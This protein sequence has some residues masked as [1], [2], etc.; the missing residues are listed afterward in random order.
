MADR[1]KGITI[2]I[3]GDTS[4]LSKALSGVNKDIKNTQ[5]QLKD[6]NK[7]LKLDPTNS[8]LIS[9]KM[10]LLG[11]SIGQTKDKLNQ[12]KS[13][14]S[15][16]DE[17]L[18]NGTVTQ[19]QYDAWQREIIATENE[20]KNLQDQLKNTDNVVQATLK[21]AGDKVSAA[22]KKISDIGSGLTTHVTAPIVAAGAASVAAWHEMDDAMDTI[23]TK[24]GAT[25]DALQ[26]MQDRAQNIA[27]TIPTD[28][29][30]AADAVGEVHTRFGL[31]GDALEDLSTQFVEFATLNNT[32]VST[33]VDNVSKVLAAFNMDTSDAGGMLNVLNSVGQ[34]TGLSMDEL[35]KLLSSNAASLQEMGLNA[36]QGAQFLGQASMAGMDTSAAMMGL[37]T[38]LKNAASDGVSMEKAMS[39]WQKTMQSSASDTDKLNATIDLFGSKAG[40]Q[41]YN[42][43]KAGKLNL[44]DLKSSMSDFE[45]N[46]SDTFNN[47]LDP[48]DNFTTMMNQMKVV[49]A[50]IGTSIGEVLGP[51]LQQV[52]E[53]IKMLT[54]AWEGLSPQMQ[55]TIV[56]AAMIAAAIGPVLIVVGKVV[57]GVGSVIKVL[58]MLANPVGIVIA[59][60]AALVAAMVVLYQKNETF[61]NGVNAMFDKIKEGFEQVKPYFQQLIDA[62][63]QL[64]TTIQPV[65][66]Q[67]GEFLMTY[68]TGIVSGISAALQP[69]IAV[70]TNVVQ[71]ITNIVKAF[72]ALFHGDLDT[73]LMYIGQAIQ[74]GLNIVKNVIMTVVNFIRGFLSAF[75]ISI[76]GI[77]TTVMTVIQTIIQTVLTAIQ[78]VVTTIVNTISTVVS[79][80]VNG[81]KTTVVSVWEA[82]KD[83]TTSIWNGIKNAIVTPINAAKEAVRSA[84]DAI[85]GIF[86]STVLKLDI[87]IPHISVSGGVA[88]FGIGGQ[89][90]LPSFNV[91][92]YKQGG[93][94]TNPTIFGMQNGRLLG[95]GEAGAEAVLPLEQLQPM[96]TNGVK[97]A[98]AGADFGGYQQNL[99]ITSPTALTPSEVAR[100]T[101]LATRNMVA[102]MKGGV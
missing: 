5:S 100:Q 42:A 52:A 32:D 7:L 69:M 91:D 36:A 88:P 89:G 51:I 33:S 98:L 93:I 57:T 23:V 30:T 21:A 25:G 67:I 10:K 74:N 3:G 38:A 87:K 6:V 85:K 20:L 81:I 79:G 76:Q 61:R 9:Q 26:D 17:G 70:V 75:G 58:G 65:V 46:V 59:A 84:I 37:K 96:I 35:S 72:I 18:K 54:A 34:A 24:T 55:Q 62:F 43:A 78:T 16:M 8:E 28:F 83:S 73:F 19:D 102:R 41:F 40:A 31:T 63:Q 86:D 71:G 45:G 60:I 2:E 1:I 56:K 97:A 101:R 49:L 99:Y 80:V 95:G 11:E 94:L 29:Q 14:Q 4:K 92:W 82:I 66:Q 13:V 22:G 12:L 53:K 48:I 50:D 27:T 64:W 44:E 47:T 68:V 77:I 39:D 90:S 15:Q